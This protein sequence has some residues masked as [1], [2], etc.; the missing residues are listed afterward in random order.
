MRSD[1][2]EHRHRI[3]VAPASLSRWA[4]LALYPVIVAQR[5]RQAIKE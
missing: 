4:V 2:R 1:R 3:G 5:Y